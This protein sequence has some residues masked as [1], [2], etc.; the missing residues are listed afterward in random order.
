[1]KFSEGL[2]RFLLK[3]YLAHE[4]DHE[5]LPIPVSPFCAYEQFHVPVRL[6]NTA[7]FFSPKNML[8]FITL[9]K[10]K[11]KNKGLLTKKKKNPQCKHNLTHAK[12]CPKHW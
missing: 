8:N 11:K 10:D 3:Q 2:V 12:N 4:Y 9:H 1:M 7:R 6:L 5:I